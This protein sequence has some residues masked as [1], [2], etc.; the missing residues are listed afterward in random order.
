MK[1]RRTGDSVLKD[2]L[3]AD[4]ADFSD[5]QETGLIGSLE[6]MGTLETQK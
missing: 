1:T 3:D 5:I 2:T 6:K 4:S